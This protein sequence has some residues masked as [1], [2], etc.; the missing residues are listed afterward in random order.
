MDIFWFLK[1]KDCLMDEVGIEAS[2]RLGILV[3]CLTELTNAPI[4]NLLLYFYNLY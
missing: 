1:L 2:K 3:E 4:T